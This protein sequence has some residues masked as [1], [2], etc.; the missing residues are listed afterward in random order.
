ME[1]D[2][3]TVIAATATTI[4]TVSAALAA[5]WPKIAAARRALG[6]LLGRR[7][8]R[9][10]VLAERPGLADAQAFAASLRAAGYRDV[11]VTSSPHG[12]A[13]IAAVVIWHPSADT[14]ADTVA[15]VDATTPAATVLIL[16][17][18][19]LPD[20]LLDDRHL[21]AQSPLRLRSDLAAVAD[22]QA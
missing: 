16:T 20:G 6:P 19:R 10:A 9:V 14:V 5:A 7:D 13:G 1:P 8:L 21:M 17:H 11:L 3:S 15:T 12:V 2:I 22:A 4:A 18:K